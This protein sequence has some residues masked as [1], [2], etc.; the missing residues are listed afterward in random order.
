[1]VVGSYSQAVPHAPDAHGAGLTVYDID[2]T[3]GTSRIRFQ[4]GAI[5]NP[6]YL[7][8]DQR[9][10]I[11]YV[12]SEVADGSE[13]TVTALQFDRNYE[14]VVRRSELRTGGTTPAYVSIVDGFALVANYGSG[15]LVS[16]RLSSDG[17]LDACVSV[18]PVQGSGPHVVRQRSAHPH[19]VIPHPSNGRIYAADLGT[20]K[21]LKLQLDRLN[22]ALTI[23]REY[24]VAPGSG[25]RHLAF[26]TVGGLAFVVSE[27]TSRL[28]VWAVDTAGDMH[29]LQDLPMLPEGTVAVSTGADIAVCKDGKRTFASNRG[30]DSV[31]VYRAADGRFWK[32]Q[33]V[34]T[35]TTP[36]SIALTQGDSHLLVANQDGDSIRVYDAREG[37]RLAELFD[38][39]VATPSCVKCVDPQVSE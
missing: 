5:A 9:N 10:R 28:G 24:G 12:L 26:D 27:L 21:L 7:C 34:P 15:S 37:A 1:V 22:G 36:R 18:L 32:S 17:H 20:D 35:G 4:D 11:A 3:S 2:L 14:S 38:V 31:T 6:A 30:H 19:C 39:P 13:G 25:P 8:I 23:E 33:I 29:E 16:L